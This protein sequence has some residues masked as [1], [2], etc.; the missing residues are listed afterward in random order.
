M[1]PLFCHSGWYNSS[2]CISLPETPPECKSKGSRRVDE[3]RADC[4]QRRFSI[5]ELTSTVPYAVRSVLRNDCIVILLLFSLAFSSCSN[6]IHYKQ[7]NEDFSNVEST[8][9][10]SHI[11][12]ILN[13][14]PKYS[15]I[16]KNIRLNKVK[17]DNDLLLDVRTADLY[18]NSKETAMAMG[19]L[20]ADLGYARYFERV[21]VCTDILDATKM[22][23]EKLAVDNDIFEEYV[24]KVEEN[25]NDEQVIFAT[26][27]SLLDTNTIVPAE[28]E[29]YGITAMF[30]CGFWVETTHLGLAQE[31]ES[32]EA[33]E[34]SLE[35]HFNVLHSINELLSQLSDGD[36]IASLKSDFSS[37][38]SRGAHSQTLG[39]DI[40]AVRNKI[41]KTI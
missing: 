29:K 40:E 12:S 35:S 37:I 1:I 18:Q 7:V 4:T 28:N 25:L 39:N 2:L 11:D 19:M 5:N 41:I 26:I 23:A 30:I 32:C 24:P 6:G 13:Q 8:A 31:S 10:K 34:N 38:E 21:Q 33:N 17:F 27:D 16:C 20:V 15:E 3:S 14:L 22:M 9:D 36:I